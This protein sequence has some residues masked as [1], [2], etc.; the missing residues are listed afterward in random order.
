MRTRDWR[1]GECPHSVLA[2][3]PLASAVEWNVR[4]R[5]ERGGDVA[6]Q[7]AIERSTAAQDALMDQVRAGIQLAG[8]FDEPVLR[9]HRLEPMH[10]SFLQLLLHSTCIALDRYFWSTPL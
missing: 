3:P 6:V 2:N 7:N 5:E 8:P 10:S 4:N 9:T 1:L